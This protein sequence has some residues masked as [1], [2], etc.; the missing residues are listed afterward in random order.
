MATF[1]TTMQFTEP[2][3]KAVKYTCKR[4]AAFQTAVQ[5]MG[6]KVTDSTGRWEPSTA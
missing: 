1:V 4:A 5:K 3:I 6:V 2:G